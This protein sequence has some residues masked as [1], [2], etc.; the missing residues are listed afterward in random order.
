M[1]FAYGK[2]T[3]NR[4]S[5][6]KYMTLF[7]SKKSKE[8][9]FLSPRPLPGQGQQ[10]YFILFKFEEGSEAHSYFGKKKLIEIPL[11]EYEKS[12]KSI[13]HAWRVE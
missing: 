1:E 10:H 8:E 9:K 11:K 4:A 12:I 13:K 3:T 6:K 5:V 2:I 7:E